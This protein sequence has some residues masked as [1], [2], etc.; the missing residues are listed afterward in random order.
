[1]FAV[2]V[3]DGAEPGKRVL[4]R[5]HLLRV[6]PLE[7]SSPVPWPCFALHSDCITFYI[8][9][10]GDEEVCLIHHCQQDSAWRIMQCP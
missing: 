7:P 6:R 8:L 4:F 2:P 10:T 5:Y 3:G 9:S 1:M